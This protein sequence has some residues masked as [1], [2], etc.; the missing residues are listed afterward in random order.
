MHLQIGGSRQVRAWGESVRGSGDQLTPSHWWTINQ[1]WYEFAI[2]CR[3]TDAAGRSLNRTVTLQY[4]RC[5]ETRL[6]CARTS[7][8]LAVVFSSSIRRDFAEETPWIFPRTLSNKHRCRTVHQHFAM[9]A[10]DSFVTNSLE[11]LNESN[12]ELHGARSRP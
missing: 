2:R 3:N 5:A 7:P 12:C 9:L 6:P 4:R 8:S 1:F 10:L 11:P